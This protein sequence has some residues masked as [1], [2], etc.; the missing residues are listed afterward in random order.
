MLSRWR[1]VARMRH[2]SLALAA[3]PGC[4]SALEKAEAQATS[5]QIRVQLPD[6]D[7]VVRT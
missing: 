1:D 6:V 4:A 5:D 7:A 2:H 3:A